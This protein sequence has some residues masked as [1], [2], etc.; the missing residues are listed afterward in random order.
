MCRFL[1]FFGVN[2]LF[3]G[4][5]GESV[6]WPTSTPASKMNGW[7]RLH[8]YVSINL[9]RK[10]LSIMLLVDTTSSLCDDEDLLSHIIRHI[11][12]QHYIINHIVS[13]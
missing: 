4:G 10:P 11:T 2:V 3:L 9:R 13:E 12:F 5:D 6:R 7:P 8:T 1:Q